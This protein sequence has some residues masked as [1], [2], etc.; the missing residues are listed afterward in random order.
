MPLAEPLDAADHQR[1]HIALADPDWNGEHRR[2]A[3]SARILALSQRLH[4][5]LLET[6]HGDHLVVQESP[7]EP[8]PARR[9]DV[10]GQLLESGSLP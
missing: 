7:R 2:H 9:L 8:A 10:D 3:A 6:G 4:R 1:A 5:Q